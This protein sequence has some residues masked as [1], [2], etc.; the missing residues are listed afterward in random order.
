MEQESVVL[1][2][3]GAAH[4]GMWKENR[5][6]VSNFANG[7]IMV[8]IDGSIREKNVI[9]VQSFR[10][11]SLES[12]G[13]DIFSTDGLGVNDLW[14]ETLLLCDAIRRGGAARLTLICPFM[15]YTRQDRQH[16]P[17]VPLSARVFCDTIAKSVDRF[18]TFDLHADQIQGFMSN[19]L[20]DHLSL[21]PYLSRY[22]HELIGDNTDNICMCSTDAGAA[23]RT[24][25]MGAYLGVNRLAMI[26]KVRDRPNSVE[27]GQLVGDVSGCTVLLIDDMIDTGGSLV[28]AHNLLTQHGAKRIIVSA[29]HG[30]LSGNAVE[31]L[32]VFDNVIFSNTLS[33]QTTMPNSMRCVCIRDFLGALIHRVD[34][35]K[36]LGTLMDPQEW[37]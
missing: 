34:R 1:Y 30:I 23:A 21:L 24:R 10:F 3:R 8:D 13:S 5:A 28:N 33:I 2:G 14:I 29:V 15:P 19:T 17:G 4:L 35:N 37:I 36:S 18:I 22:V 27:S 11:S 25:R 7:E 31:R 32:S 20:F 26:S 12:T 6:T 9:L 16:H